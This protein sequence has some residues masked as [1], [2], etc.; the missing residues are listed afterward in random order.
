M[1][2]KILSML[3]SLTLVMGFSTVSFGAEATKAKEKY[4]VNATEK[5]QTKTEQ[6][7]EEINSQ[8]NEE[9]VP[10]IVKRFCKEKSSKIIIFYY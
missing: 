8:N 9:D 5:T 3:L 2:R 4:G 1:S 10:Q 7:E 6:S